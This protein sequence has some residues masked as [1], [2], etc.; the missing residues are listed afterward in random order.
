M[1]AVE[2][3]AP[4]A[5]NSRRRP[6]PR[7]GSGR[8]LRGGA[9]EELG[10]ARGD[11]PDLQPPPPHPRG[12]RP[13]IEWRRDGGIEVASMSGGGPARP[14]PQPDGRPAVPGWHLTT[15]HSAARLVSPDRAAL[16]AP[17]PS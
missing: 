16:L 4:S 15:P 13:P 6:R 14:T 5:L 12:F 3:P 2:R 17:P 9:V 11:G 8:R 1:E 10:A 7:A